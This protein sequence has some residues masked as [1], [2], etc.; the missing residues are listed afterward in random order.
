[1]NDRGHHIRLLVTSRTAT[2]A[3]LAPVLG[4]SEPA[5]HDLGT[6]REGGPL[7]QQSIW[8]RRW[9]AEAGEIEELLDQVLEWL[10]SRKFALTAIDPAALFKV[11]CN[12]ADARL[13]ISPFVAAK[14]VE[15]QVLLLVDTSGPSAGEA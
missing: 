6:R 3:D 10:A 1:M 8:F 13:A 9:T 5:H 12:P 14:L 7:R 15:L 4:N 2:L 11:V